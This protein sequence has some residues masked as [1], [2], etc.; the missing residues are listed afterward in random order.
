MVIG[1]LL[2]YSSLQ[3]P[4]LADVLRQETASRVPKAVDDVP[5]EDFSTLTDEE[6]VK[7]IHQALLVKPLVLDLS[8]ATSQALESKMEVRDPWGD[9]ARVAGL[10]ITK[11]VPYQG[12]RALWK[13]RPNEFDLNPPRG[14]VDHRAVRV[15]MTVRE[16]EAQR[17]VDYIQETFDKI[18]TY[19][20]RQA[21]LISEYNEQL[22]T[23]IAP[24]VEARRKR[25][26][27]A[28]DILDQ[29]R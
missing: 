21:G 24:Y 12:D 7:S 26:S 9:S 2:F 8:A 22:P 1:E 15:G 23:Q 19:I 6:I 20:G 18:Q 25:L 14:E 5:H 10:K 16:E 28:S 17:A 3:S 11:A 27:R 4:S 13:L 29:L